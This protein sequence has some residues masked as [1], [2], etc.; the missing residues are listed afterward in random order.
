M[1][2]Y[3]C[4]FVIG[5]QAVNQYAASSASESEEEETDYEDNSFEVIFNISACHSFVRLHIHIG[6]LCAGG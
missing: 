5:L 3:R 1:L 6:L 2:M 4:V